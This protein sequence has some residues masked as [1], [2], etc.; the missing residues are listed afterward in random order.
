MSESTKRNASTPELRVGTL[1]EVIDNICTSTVTG[2][3]VARD[4]FSKKA[5]IRDFFSDEKKWRPL[6]RVDL[7]RLRAE[8]QRKLGLLVD[9]EGIHDAV[10]LVCSEQERRADGSGVTLTRFRGA[11]Q[12]AFARRRQ[13][14]N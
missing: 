14:A 7:I 1:T 6:T 11:A 9:R 8:L 12:L 5:F 2:C 4:E 13:A 10:A 3:M